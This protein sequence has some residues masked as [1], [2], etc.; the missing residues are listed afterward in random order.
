MIED[1]TAA[2]LRGC[3]CMLKFKDG[4]VLYLK[5]DALD[6]DREDSDEWLS[7]AEDFINNT[8]HGS[9]FQSSKIAVCREEIK[10][11]IRI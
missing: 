10:Y 6:S 5:I 11:I 9:N 7:E 2:K 1:Q 3:N 8:G 4:E